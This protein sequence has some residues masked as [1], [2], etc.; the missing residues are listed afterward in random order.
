MGVSSNWMEFKQDTGNNGYRFR[1]GTSDKFIIEETDG[2]T[3]A[4]GTNINEFSIDGTLSGS[5][6]DAVP[7]ELAVK[8]YVDTEQLWSRSTTIISPK[9]S[10]DSLKINVINEE[11]TD[12]G[13]TIEDCKIENIG[14]NTIEID[15]PSGYKYVFKVNGTPVMELT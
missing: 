13:V 2:V 3:L 4:A 10:G 5:S 14:S 1:F 11:S 15:I 12:A 9:T 7:T 6:D 8:T